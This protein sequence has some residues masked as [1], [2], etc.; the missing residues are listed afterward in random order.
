M[1]SELSTQ[2]PYVGTT[3]GLVSN[4]AVGGTDDEE[5]ADHM[6]AAAEGPAASVAILEHDQVD[7]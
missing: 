7:E 2:I 1:G 6:K 4:T 5:L 3:R